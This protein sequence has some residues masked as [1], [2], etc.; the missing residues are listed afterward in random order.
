MKKWKRLFFSVAVGSALALGSIA[1]TGHYANA[2]NWQLLNDTTGDNVWTMP[3]EV[4]GTYCINDWGNT[5]PATTELG[6]AVNNV[7]LQYTVTCDVCKD[8]TMDIRL[9]CGE[10]YA[11]GCNVK[12]YLV[13]NDS[14][15]ITEYAESTNEDC[16]K[17]LSVLNMK[18]V[19]DITG[20]KT[21]YLST[22]PNA[23]VTPTVCFNSNTCHKVYIDSENAQLPAGGAL[24]CADTDKAEIAQF[25]EQF[26]FGVGYS[27]YTPT[28]SIIDTNGECPRCSFA[29]PSEGVYNSW[30]TNDC[31]DDTFLK[32]NSLAPVKICDLT[33]AAD[34]N[35]F[36]DPINIGTAAGNLGGLDL[37]MTATNGFKGVEKVSLVEVTAGVAKAFSENNGKYTLSLNATDLGNLVNCANKNLVD[38]T[39]CTDGDNCSCTPL[40]GGDFTLNV[41]YKFNQP[42]AFAVANVENWSL[43][44]KDLDI[45]THRW[46]FNG[47]EGTTPYMNTGGQNYAYDAFVKIFNDYV[48]PGDVYVDIFPD[49]GEPIYNVY[50]GKVGAK[51]VFLMWAK[52]PGEKPAGVT[53]IVTA[54]KQQKGIDLAGSFAARFVVTVPANFVHG[55]V[56]QKSL[57]GDRVMPIDKDSSDRGLFLGNSP[58]NQ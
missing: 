12:F 52:Y 58:Q 16:S 19:K 1:G 44:K 32:Y 49:N 48:T 2:S 37:S 47:W 7:R 29:G 13:A 34:Y 18:F 56:V 35:I 8:S 21:L 17:P 11:S 14:G 41:K 28:K 6:N 30:D 46:V 33:K 22:K 55:V 24:E 54:V 4:K 26:R 23:I 25:V 51:Q 57:Q 43:Q 38:I 20:P 50:L 10:V 45:L 31:C 36:D 5:A 42:T 39:V 15:T 9:S 53:D 3:A 40:E 27:E